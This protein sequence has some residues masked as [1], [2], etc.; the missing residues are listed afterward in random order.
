MISRHFE[1]VFIYASESCECT[2]EQCHQVGEALV[3]LR[4]GL[5]VPFEV[6]SIDFV[7]EWTRANEWMKVFDRYFV[8]VVCLLGHGGEVRFCL[9]GLFDVDSLESLVKRELTGE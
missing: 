5:D 9:E 1:I 8:P 7:T 6:D 3:N 2:L 4:A